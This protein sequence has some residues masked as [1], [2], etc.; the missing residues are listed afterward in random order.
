MCLSFLLAWTVSPVAWHRV[1]AA[2]SP[3]DARGGILAAIPIFLLLYGLVVAAGM[4]SLPLLGAP[5]EGKPLVS[6]LIAAKTGPV[7]GALLFAAVLAA[8]V[9]TL[10]AG[11][12]TGAMTL[13]RDLLPASAG[14][15]G[16]GLA[17]GRLA[18]VLTVG[19]AFLAATRFTSILATLGL[20]S[21][22]MAEGLFLPGAAMFLLKRRLP[23]AGF[24]SLLLGGGFALAS[25]LAGAGVWS[26]GLPVWPDTLPYGL[27]L[28]A[29]G[30]VLGTS[31]D[32]ARG[33]KRI[34]GGLG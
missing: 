19:L 30:F 34:S 26:P 8:I 22:I 23:A 28:S 29:A 11:I 7:L 15:G 14:F 2:R 33:S 27:G 24:L 16:K 17:L 1:R 12:N 4:L 5:P 31:W 18:T 3:R 13:A 10:D 21:E 6:V 9:S 25:F 20:A 32:L